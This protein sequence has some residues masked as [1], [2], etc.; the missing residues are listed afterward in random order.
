MNVVKQYRFAG[1]FSLI[2]AILFTVSGCHLMKKT[3]TNRK[4]MSEEENIVRKVINAQADARFI[5]MRMT[6]KAEEDNNRIGF[7]GTV[8]IERNR[9][10]S[11]VLRSTI[12]IELARVYAN[13]DSVWMVSKILNIKEKTDWKLA[14]GKLGYP[15]D[16]YAIQGILLHSLFTSSGDQISH[17]VTNLIVKNDNENLHL[18]SN[19]HNQAE[20]EREKYLND[21]LINKETF[22][23]EDSK[24]RDINGQWIVDVKY[25]YNKDNAIK[26]IQLK[27]I[28][29]ERNFAVEINV[30]KL[31][32]KDFIEINFDRF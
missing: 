13:L 8:K 21:F 4:V 29:S 15:V 23:I 17:L 26:K 2:M 20:L 18:V 11:I 22:I 6:G 1:I 19:K 14:V 10:I 30:V 5:E 16:F 3:V 25:L 31:D 12:G 7:I 24:I 27:G 28:D 32:L 9:Q